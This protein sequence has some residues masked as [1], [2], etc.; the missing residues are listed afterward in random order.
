[1]GQS[2]YEMKGRETYLFYQCYVVPERPITES[3]SFWVKLNFVRP[4]FH[5]L[6]QQEDLSN[7]LY[8]S[9]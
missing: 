9:S 3:L 1:M 7:P 6:Q 8:K 4:L 2:G 5:R